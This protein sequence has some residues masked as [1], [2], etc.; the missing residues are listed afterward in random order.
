MEDEADKVPSKYIVQK[1]HVQVRC[2]IIFIDFEGR[3][4]GKSVKNLLT[5]VS[6]RKMV[7]CEILY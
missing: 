7:N 3:S 6:P 5:G 2:G 4:D 1:L